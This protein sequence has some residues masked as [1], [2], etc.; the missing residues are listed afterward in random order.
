MARKSSR[1]QFHLDHG[2]G[3]AWVVDT[4]YDHAIPIGD[5]Q[6]LQDFILRAITAYLEISPKDDPF[7]EA[8][9]ALLEDFGDPELEELKNL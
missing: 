5:R 8:A 6:A 9:L 4:D 2:S 1:H 3:K 7:R